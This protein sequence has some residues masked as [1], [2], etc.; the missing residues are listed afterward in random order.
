MPPHG[1]GMTNATHSHNPEYPEDSWNLYSFLDEST[2]A[3]NVTVPGDVLGVFKPHARRLEPLPELVS[4]ADHEIII[5]ARFTSPANVRKLCIIG[6]GS[7]SAHHPSHVK[8][9]TNQD[10]I[11]FT[12]ISS[13]TPAQEFG[14]AINDRGEIELTTVMRPFTNVTSLTF[15]FSANHGDLDKTSIGYIGMQGEHTHYRR[16]A[17]DTVY[18]VLCTGQDIVQPEESAGAHGAHGGGG[19]MH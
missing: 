12:S 14:L 4:D 1:P 18:E 10:H 3:L 2:S 5:T 16:E 13:F 8:C 11:D 6:G 9:Y 17:V 19:H 15:Y 7:D